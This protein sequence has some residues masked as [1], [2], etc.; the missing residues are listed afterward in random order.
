MNL[1]ERISNMTVMQKTVVVVCSLLIFSSLF[2][3][4][5]DATTQTVTYK[6]RITGEVYCE[7]HYLFGKLINSTCEESEEVGSNWKNEY[8]KNLNPS[9]LI[10][11][12]S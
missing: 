4:C 1:K 9:V 2:Y 8:A 12:Q 7:E 11:N 6:N 10:L 5:I 3:L